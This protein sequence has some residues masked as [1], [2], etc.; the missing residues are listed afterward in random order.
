[1]HIVREHQIAPTSGQSGRRNE[2][3]TFPIEALEALLGHPT[4]S[5]LTQLLRCGGDE[6]R[7]ARLWGWSWRQ[8]DRY[9]IRAGH[10]PATVWPDLWWGAVP[11]PLD[12]RTSL[13]A[14]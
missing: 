7:T 9:A 5:A 2:R 12:E 11:E 1:M 3:T 14:A 13:D 10:H 4:V 8:A 6:V